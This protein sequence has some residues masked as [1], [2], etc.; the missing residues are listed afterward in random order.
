MDDTPSPL[1][2]EPLTDDDKQWLG[3]LLAETGAEGAYELAEYLGILSP[4]HVGMDRPP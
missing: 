2:E 4:T 1:R 3:E